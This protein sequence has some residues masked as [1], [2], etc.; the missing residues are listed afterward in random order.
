MV[1]WGLAVCFNSCSIEWLLISKPAA[2]NNGSS[3]NAAASSQSAEAA[4]SSAASA[5]LEIGRFATATNSEY[6]V[7]IFPS[8]TNT[9]AFTAPT[10]L[11]SSDLAWPA[12]SFKPNKPSPTTVRE[13]RPRLI[14]PA[15]KWDH[16]PQIIPKDPYL[17]GWN[18]T[19]FGNATAYAA[20]PA[21]K[22]NMDGASGI[23]D[24]AREVKM[25]VKAF[26]YAYRMTNDTKWSDS[27]WREIEVC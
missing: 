15:Y 6:M 14:A 12:D 5:K 21:V 26:A 16:L 27:A 8:A 17:R 2:K 9:A 19:I 20:L 4:A 13:D 18:D 1:Y 23:L 25:R 10:F 24:N 7:P 22:Y 11:A 3:G